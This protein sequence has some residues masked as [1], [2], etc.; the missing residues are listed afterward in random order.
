MR[1]AIVFPEASSRGGVEQVALQT[2]EHLAPRYATSF[3][4]YE[5]EALPATLNVR[6]VPLQRPR[7]TP[8]ALHPAAFR[9]AA[10]RCLP[11][12]KGTITISHGANAPPG[13]V[14]HVHSVH[15]A[16]LAAS[17]GA[18][19]NGVPVPGAARYLLARHQVLL[20]LEWDYFR[21]HRPR[22]IVTVSQTV[23]EELGR[24][25][26]V[27]SDVIRV[28]PNGYDP[29]RCSPARRR[30]MRTEMRARHGVSEEAVV[31]LF[32]AN[33]LRRKGFGTLIEAVAR[34]GDERL[35]VHVFGRAPLD[36][37]QQGIAR[38]GLAG[39]VR[40]HGSIAD[41]GCAH[42]LADLMVLPTQY[43]AFALSI[44]EALASGLPVI[45]TDL[46]GAR[47]RV[48]HDVNGLLLADPLDGTE[49]AALLRVALDPQRRE[50]WALH[51]PAA[52]SDLA[53][54]KVMTRLEQILLEVA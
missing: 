11:H 33:E 15:R 41:I 13:D 19:V 40:H 18:R 22:R 1:P 5:L 38:V 6:H 45:T 34:S 32:V 51:A 43:E 21:R 53:W 8:P 10:T 25:Y 31:L 3:V 30:A 50:R 35:E 12:E 54:P 29:R 16:W 49:L 2:L 52:V 44:V 9:V 4:G 17:R 14:Y 46:P 39:R 20:A 7:W 27:P 26:S 37:F 42:A 47:D 28:V 23:A 36:S 48:E 24:F